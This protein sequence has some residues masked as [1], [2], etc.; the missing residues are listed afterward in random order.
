[1]RW[2]DGN[3]NSTDMSLSK[4]RETVSESQGS[5]VCCSSWGRKQRDTTEQLNNNLLSQAES[6]VGPLWL[7]FPVS[8]SLHKVGQVPKETR[9]Y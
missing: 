6:S 1:M 9:R 3:I 5:L 7:P 2:L 8:H 4:L